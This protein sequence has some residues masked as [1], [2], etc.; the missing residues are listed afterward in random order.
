MRRSD[1][2]TKALRR[3]TADDSRGHRGRCREN[4]L[5]QV[6]DDENNGRAFDRLV[7]DELRNVSERAADHTFIRPTGS[8]HHGDRAICAVKRR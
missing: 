2:I 1:R 8:H 3:E 6:L 4:P 7:R 5:R